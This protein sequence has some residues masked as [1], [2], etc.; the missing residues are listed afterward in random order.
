MTTTLLDMQLTKERETKERF[1]ASL[2]GRPEMELTRGNGFT[3]AEQQQF[4]MAASLTFARLEDA[5][6][7]MTM[8]ALERGLQAIGQRLRNAGPLPQVGR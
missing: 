5:F 6:Q 7:E 8:E 1:F 2:P 4:L 3:P